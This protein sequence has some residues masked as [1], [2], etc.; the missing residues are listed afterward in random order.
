MSRSQPESNADQG[1]GSGNLAPSN[2]SSEAESGRSPAGTFPGQSPVDGGSHRVRGTALLILLLIL[3]G[4]TRLAAAGGALWL[5]EAWTLGPQILGQVNS[6]GDVFTGIHHENNHYWNTLWAW[7]LGPERPAW[8]YRI[9]SVIA[10]VVTTWCGWQLG[11]RRSFPSAVFVASLLA[12]SYLLVHYG[13]EAR[14]YS[15]AMACLV[16]AW[17]LRERLAV[18][19]GWGVLLAIACVECWG[20]AAQ[21]VFVCHLAGVVT[22]ALAAVAW[23]N[24]AERYQGARALWA[25]VP[26]GA[27]LGWLYAVDLGRAF[28]AGGI[29]YSPSL[30]VMQTMSLL[31]GGPLAGEALKWGALMGV[32]IC[33]IASLWL[34]TREKPLVKYALVAGVLAPWA[35][36]VVEARAEVYPRYFLPGATCGLIVIGLA[37]GEL[38]RRGAGWRFVAGGA[39]WALLACQGRHVARLID[40]GRGDPDA[41]RNLIVAE[42]P[43]KNHE[44]E[45]FCD[46]VFRFEVWLGTRRL[47]GP[48]RLRLI[49]PEQAPMPP[50]AWRLDQRTE[51]DGPFPT[52]QRV[53]PFQYEL[54]KVFPS[55]GLSGWSTG[56]YQ[57]VHD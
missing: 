44:I 48:P 19:P 38:W 47:E 46:Q 24:S 8:W 14:G 42:S 57:R 35:I 49:P 34:W 54:Q 2:L 51:L 17:L 37:L 43:G 9:P 15:M 22:L 4:G 11:F 52:Q 45:V 5:D 41:V 33:G 3:A 16:G 53:G 28:N 13:S 36:L 21:P 29:I 32:G 26:A 55:A 1:P 23:G 31:W 25:T 39:A 6:V 18:N 10:G 27:W 20:L 50:P 56:V 12:G 40:Q 30:I 7:C